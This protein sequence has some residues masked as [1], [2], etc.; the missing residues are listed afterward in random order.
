M[1]FARTNRHTSHPNR[2]R[3][4]RIARSTTKKPV[5]LDYHPNQSMTDGNK[6]LISTELIGDEEITL[7][8]QTGSTYHESYHV[9]FTDFKKM[10]STLSK[11]PSLEEYV[12]N[13]MV[14]MFGNIFEDTRIESAAK[15]LFRGANLYLQMKNFALLEYM[16][17][18]EMEKD[19]PE[20]H[21]T[22]HVVTSQAKFGY[23][24]EH[25]V[26]P[27][28][29]LRFM[30]R[31]APV[32]E[33]AVTAENTA[34]QLIWSEIVAYE[35]MKWYP[36]TLAENIEQ[37]KK[38]M[39]GLVL[40]IVGKAPPGCQPI[41]VDIDEPLNAIVVILE[42]PDEQGGSQDC[43]PINIVEI[44][45]LRDEKKDQDGE[46]DSNGSSGSS[47]SSDS[48]DSGEDQDGEEGGESSGEQAQG[49]DE[50]SLSNNDDGF[51]GD[52]KD[53]SPGEKMIDSHPELAPETK[54]QMK[55][56][57]KKAKEGVAKDLRAQE[58]REEQLSKDDQGYVDVGNVK[59]VGDGHKVHYVREGLD[60]DYD[61]YLRIK[62]EH[63][64]S[65][66]TIANKIRNLLQDAKAAR[67]VRNLPSGDLDP[68]SL[69]RVETSA[70]LFKR[71]AIPRVKD[72]V[73]TILV[74]HSLSMN[75]SSPMGGKKDK[76]ASISCIVVSEI[77]SKIPDIDFEIIGFN[78]WSGEQS[79]YLYKSYGE[80][81]DDRVKG[82]LAIP[83]AAT[84][85]VDAAVLEVAVARQ[86]TMPQE[87]KIIIIISDGNPTNSPYK[88]MTGAQ[89]LKHALE[90]FKN[91]KII[92]IGITGGMEYTPADY[93]RYHLIVKDARRLPQELVS[94]VRKLL[95]R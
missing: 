81:Y 2:R 64:K 28:R 52:S 36:K 54:Q 92:G 93:Y 61:K 30:K 42:D 65:S 13:E 14:H 32:I 72:S 7:V 77:L 16:L 8:V 79:Y 57:L 10:A 17:K 12:V 49:G 47:D 23:T 83:R 39:E 44:L 35:F 95:R 15:H 38:E 51:P 89:S 73:F 9:M 94:V 80:P 55:T 90:K 37:M 62:S 22:I 60:R 63:T 91:R 71:T 48:S 82:A 34:E 18:P 70:S 75:K 87:Q 26:N 86:D 76:W 45:D 50:S 27:K 24:P 6:I 3:L 78:G 53:K 56:M 40:L 20:G 25:Y 5:S 69:Y 41:D 46:D 58:K 4:Q 84:G 85:N 31:I 88:G 33:T 74:D 68:R 43:P 19:K 66:S 21:H 59:Q 29:Q 11:E 67:H 1:N